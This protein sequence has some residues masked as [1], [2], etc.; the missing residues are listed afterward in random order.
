[1][2]VRNTTVAQA[3]RPHDLL[4]RAGEGE[5]EDKVLGDSGAGV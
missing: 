1:M 2:Y 3:T 4:L 5:T